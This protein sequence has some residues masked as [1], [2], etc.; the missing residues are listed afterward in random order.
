MDFT[1]GIITDG[2]VDPFITRTIDSIRVLNIPRCEVIIVGNTTIQNDDLVRTIPFNESIK[3]SWITRKKNIICNEAKY[4]NIVLLHDYIVF[5]SNWYNGF[6]QFGN[7]FEVCINKVKNL[8]GTRFR[9]YSLFINYVQC[10][11]SRFKSQCL[12][13]YDYKLTPITAK[14]SY[15]SGA[16]YVLKKS[17]AL[18]FPLDE[19]K[20][21]GDG[22][23]V[24]FCYKIAQAGILIKMNPYSIV[25]FMKQKGACDW[26]HEI[27]SSLVQLLDSFTDESVDEWKKDPEGA[28]LFPILGLS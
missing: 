4:E 10:H 22:D 21:H 8:D 15:I 3:R 17:T 18:K 20:S 23:D 27:D 25:Q 26:E 19:A 12:L 11:D 7:D 16:Y 6:L 2:N 5:D 24:D 14:L 9:D 13:P 1:F 28:H